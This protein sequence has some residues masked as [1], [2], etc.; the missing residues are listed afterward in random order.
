MSE[1]PAEVMR[2][3]ASLLR[4]S[5]KG[6][7]APPWHVS[8]LDGTVRYAHWGLVA[9]AHRGADAAWIAAMHPGVGGALAGWL[10]KEAEQAATAVS[11]TQDGWLCGRCWLDVKPGGC[12]HWDGA[13]SVARAILGEQEGGN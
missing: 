8:G 3:A 13:L 4:E 10:E 2:R 6:A 12:G 11:G 5:A 7:S 9:S 1:H